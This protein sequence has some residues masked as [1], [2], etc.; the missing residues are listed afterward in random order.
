[1]PLQNAHKYEAT[2]TVLKTTVTAKEILIISCFFSF[3]ANVR[4]YKLKPSSLTKLK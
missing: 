2:G 1:M 3:Y 4:K